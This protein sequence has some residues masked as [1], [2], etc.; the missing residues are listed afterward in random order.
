MNEDFKEVRNGLTNYL[1]SCLQGMPYDGVQAKHALISILAEEALKLSKN[2]N[3][4][5]ELFAIKPL[6]RAIIV[7]FQERIKLL[8]TA[9]TSD[10][11]N[12]QICEYNTLINTLSN[13]LDII[14]E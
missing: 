10:A 13:F 14:K 8:Q 7:I 2:E 5:I 4:E 11:I 9:P 12:I 3:E 6:I 1:F